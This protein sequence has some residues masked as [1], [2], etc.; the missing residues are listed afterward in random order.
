[1]RKFALI[2]ALS[3]ALHV[4]ITLTIP[5]RVYAQ[6][7]NGT[8]G[9]GTSATP[10]NSVCDGISDSSL[11]SACQRCM[12]SD[13][14]TGTWTAIGCISTNPNALLEKILGLAT[15][16]SG[17]IAFL[18]ILFGGFQIMTS[19][20]NPEQLNAGRELVS[21]AITGLLLMLFSVFILQFVGVNIIGI[22][23]FG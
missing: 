20:G 22:P 2:S 3:L 21:S 13:T 16:A 11:Q 15:G 18:L 10:T 8:V 14:N 4:F 12:G 7:L 1:M 23:G 5:V 17:G 19:A 6:Q 9:T